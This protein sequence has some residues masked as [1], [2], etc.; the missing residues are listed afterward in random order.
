MGRIPLFH[1]GVGAGRVSALM[2]VGPDAAWRSASTNA[3]NVR[4]G[5]LIVGCTRVYTGLRTSFSESVRASNRVKN[6]K[7]QTQKMADA[8]LMSCS[9]FNCYLDS[10]AQRSELRRS[11]L[12]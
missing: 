8:L 11:R 9:W 6:A 10:L 3:I 1:A 2:V 5:L 4:A 12:P 7:N